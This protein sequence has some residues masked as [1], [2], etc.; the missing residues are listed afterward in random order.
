MKE[1]LMNSMRKVL[2][3]TMTFLG[4]LVVSTAMAQ[5]QGELT[6]EPA[7]ACEAI[8]CLS[9]GSRPGE[10]D[11]ALSRYFGINY[12]FW[13]DTVQGRLDFLR[14]CPEASDMFSA[15]MPKIVEAL[16]KGAGR[17]DAAYLNETLET[18]VQ[19]KYCNAADAVSDDTPE[20]GTWKWAGDGCWVK[21]VEVVSTSK[22]AL[23][24]AYANAQY[25]YFLG[26]HYVGDPMD[27]GH[28]VDDSAGVQ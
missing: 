9:S 7:L 22:P 1:K 26:V 18:L 15:N 24:S 14:L 27:G 28:W 3:A 5:Q 2:S 10:C 11:P 16:A 19:K 13:S 25:S 8:L 23:C 12:K 20:N 4:S 21:D 6:G 17:C